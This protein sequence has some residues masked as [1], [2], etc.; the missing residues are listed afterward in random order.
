MPVKAPHAHTA[1]RALDVER[2][3][4]ADA[5]EVLLLWAMFEVMNDIPASIDREMSNG[6]ARN[7][8]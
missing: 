7:S 6:Q 3:K 2:G 5:L 1:R 4:L 8:G